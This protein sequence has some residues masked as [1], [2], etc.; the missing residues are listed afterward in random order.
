MNSKELEEL[1]IE[2]AALRAQVKHLEFAKNP[3]VCKKGHRFFAAVTHP[4]KSEREWHCPSCVVNELISLK[5]D[6]SRLDW[7]DSQGAMIVIKDGTEE[8]H[9]IFGDLAGAGTL[10]KYIDEEMI[11]SSLTFGKTNIHSNHEH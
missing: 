9:C 1:K 8:G 2:C 11:A 4:M 7:L 3:I 6:G 10:R 5:A